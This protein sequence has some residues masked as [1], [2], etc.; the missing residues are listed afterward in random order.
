[1]TE[2]E[3]KDL[4]LNKS[5]MCKIIIKNKNETYKFGTGFFC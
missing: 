2:E 4:Y 3:M 5:S 1:M